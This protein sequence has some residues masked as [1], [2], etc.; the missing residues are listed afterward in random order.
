MTG[1]WTLLYPKVF[2]PFAGKGGFIIDI[3]DRDV[4]VNGSRNIAIKIINETIYLYI[5]LG[6]TQGV[7][8]L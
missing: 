8:V 3:I 7:K 1:E 5:S 2:E 4:D 6:A